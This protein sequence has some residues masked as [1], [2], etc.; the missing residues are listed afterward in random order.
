MG[1]MAENEKLK[2]R[3]QFYNNLAV[4]I[5]TGGIL[6]PVLTHAHQPPDHLFSLESLGSLVLTAFAWGT[7]F[8]LRSTAEGYL[9]KLQD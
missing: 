4:G 3:A 2:L 9:D 6:V 1:I 7:V 5:G 8:W